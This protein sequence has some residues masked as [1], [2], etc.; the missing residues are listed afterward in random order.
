LK[1]KNIQK[2]GWDNILV[3]GI[4][5]A[6]EKPQVEFSYDEETDTAKFYFGGRLADSEEIANGITLLYEECQEWTLPCSLSINL[7]GISI[8]NFKK[9][10]NTIKD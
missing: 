10:I 2:D 3:N 7:S 5:N 9:I 8:R 6:K 1:E 4:R